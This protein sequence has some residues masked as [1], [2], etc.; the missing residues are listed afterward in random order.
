MALNFE[1]CSRSVA[2][3]DRMGGLTNLAEHI[4]PRPLGSFEILPA[5][6]S[7]EPH[8]K[9]GQLQRLSFLSES[10]NKNFS[11]F[12]EGNFQL[13]H[14]E[15]QGNIENYIG[16]A[17]VPIGVAGPLL[18]NGTSA[19]GQYYVPLAT[20]E[21]AL[22]ASYGRGMKICTQNGGVTSVCISEGVQ[23]C[24]YFQFHSISE[25]GLFVQWVIGQRSV[26]DILVEQRSKHA[27]L[28]D[29]SVGI[30]GNG[31]ILSFQFQTGDA[32]GQNMVTF[33]TDALC[34]FI[35][36]N[37]PVSVKKWYLE[38]N[39]AG[40]KKATWKAFQ[41]VR[42]KKVTAEI[43]LSRKSVEHVLKTT[44]ELMVDYWRSSTLAALQSGTV[45]AQ[46]HVA[47]G[48][49]AIFLACGQDVACVSEAS[50]GVT[51]MELTNSGDLYVSL[52]LPNLIVGTIGGGTH[53]PTQSKCLDLLD[54]LG[55]GK[56]K[57]FAEVC[58][59]V[60]IAG[61]ISIAAALASGQFAQAHKSLGRKMKNDED[62][63]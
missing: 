32:A 40:D 5:I 39:Y 57:R 23:R 48:L 15:L 30:E 29:I 47:N 16:M 12:E 60:A 13:N 4:R 24:P 33:C 1:K 11:E 51:R 37:S 26:F 2:R 52:T 55:D 18:I 6:P 9:S 62:D 36:E 43:R 27:K 45:G 53:L 38:S 7:K 35:V 41:E 61:E 49:T 56:A 31:V 58:A 21:G 3:I 10:L 50:V 17:Q 46:G 28:E 42:G 20:T 44:P 22:V 34:D 59:A 25:V 19:K 8:S 63:A 54:C 14:G